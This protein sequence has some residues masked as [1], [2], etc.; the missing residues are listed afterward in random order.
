MA[1]SVKYS[2]SFENRYGKIVTVFLLADGDFDSKEIFFTEDP[3]TITHDGA[4]DDIFQTLIPSKAT[5]NLLLSE[6]DA[7]LL[8]DI[9][10]MDENTFGVLITIR[11]PAP[12]PTL[13][14]TWEGWLVP[15]QQKRTFTYSPQPISL[16][17]IDPVSRSKGQ[18]LLNDDGSY[19]Y[20]KQTIKYIVDRCLTGVFTPDT[21]TATYNLVVDSDL[22][23]S[24]TTS[25]TLPPLF[26]QIQVNAEAFNDDVGRP[27]SAYQVLEMIAKALFMRVFYENGNIYFMDILQYS[28]VNSSPSIPLNT[29]HYANEFTTEGVNTL[30][31]GNTEN[32]TRVRTF[33]DS[34]CKFS[35][36]NTI[37]LLLDGNLINWASISG[38]YRL[39]QWYYSPY[40]MARP[41]VY[42]RRYGTG[43]AESPYGI[44][45]RYTAEPVDAF[46]AEHRFFDVICS[47]T[48]QKASEGEVYSLTARLN[49]PNV[50]NIHGSIPYM[51]GGV[52]CVVPYFV[53]AFNESNPA[54]SYFLDSNQWQ[55][56]NLSGTD[57]ELAGQPDWLAIFG[58][59]DNSLNGSTPDSMLYRPLTDLEGVG[60]YSLFT[61]ERTVKDQEFT[62]DFP[63][64]PSKFKGIFYVFIHPAINADS[65]L[66]AKSALPLSNITNTIV[67]SCVLSQ[68]VNDK[69]EST[70]EIQYLQ[71][72]IRTSQDNKT[73]EIDLNTT[74]NKS[75][76]GALSNAIDY[77]EG[78]DTIVAGTNLEKIALSGYPEP[79]Y[80][81]VSLMAYNAIAQMWMNYAQ[82]QI[83]IDT[84][85]NRNNFYD[86]VNLGTF[87]DSEKPS[88]EIYQN[89]FIQTKSSYKLKPCTRNLT[90]IST[91]AVQRNISTNTLDEDNDFSEF[92]Y[93]K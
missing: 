93:L 17:A 74:I 40:L 29:I 91:K 46:N 26:E 38:G 15:D 58:D 62:R 81:G 76:S 47:K 30:L 12:L 8:E 4:E 48:I 66:Y 82:Y 63:E 36:K 49:V 69:K 7:D 90:V 64:L 27:I 37:G 61:I 23:L 9:N 1:A 25:T 57:F 71:R 45:I 86:G 22:T 24:N 85:G 33:R 55:E 41:D 78:S 92:Y 39:A 10:G 72:E 35:Y 56:K 73:R 43:R 14:Y 34:I 2:G 65:D 70:G 28:L 44:L 21:S 6:D 5:I 42:S 88:T 32:I 83:D 89:L 16:T 53:I 18:K 77:V 79:L 59:Y 87:Y 67:F 51:D 75:V 52:P 11:N 13:Q 19:I 54:K 50:E 60:G 31:T 84:I 80:S 20:G 68:K 3:V